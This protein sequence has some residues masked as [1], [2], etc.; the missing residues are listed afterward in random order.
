MRGTLFSFIFLLFLSS[1]FA[2]QAVKNVDLNKYM[3]LWYEVAHV[4][5]S[6]QKNCF[7]NTKAR[8]KLREDGKIDVRNTCVKKGGQRQVAD[9]VGQIVDTQN[10]SELKISFV[11]LLKE[12]GLFS[13]QYK[14][15][16][17][18]PNYQYAII[19]EDSLE[20]GWILSRKSGLPLAIFTQLEREI[21]SLGY[22]SCHFVTSVQDTGFFT[23]RTPLCEL[24]KNNPNSLLNSNIL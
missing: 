24:V 11:P 19:G 21:R 9:G 13:G 15:L 22:D 23:K 16:S 20:Y 14:I 10:Q 6:E 1:A 17:L 7:K 3:G 5:N 12:L 8:Y 2:V 18:D 4:P